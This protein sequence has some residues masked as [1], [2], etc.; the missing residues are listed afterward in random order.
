MIGIGGQGG[1]PFQPTQGATPQGTAAPGQTAAIVQQGQQ[2]HQSRHNDLTESLDTRMPNGQ[3][4]E[5][6]IKAF[7]ESVRLSG[8]YFDNLRPP[9]F[10]GVQADFELWTY[11][12]TW[13]TQTK[14][15]LMTKM[16]TGFE[17]IPPGLTL[18]QMGFW[19]NGVMEHSDPNLGTKVIKCAMELHTYLQQ[20]LEKSG[21]DRIMLPHCGQNG[22]G[23][24]RQLH[25]R[26]KPHTSTSALRDLKWI[27][28][29]PG[30]FQAGKELT[31]SLQ[32]DEVQL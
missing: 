29:T 32:D 22:F 8:R 21:L 25:E 12:F 18:L 6:H 20:S 11:R 16:I 1:T 13:H 2:S 31:H 26:F 3:E 30:L 28:F 24:W 27:V 14:S 10:T 4:Y 17:N 9:E 23:V 7:M 15:T 19:A 5:G